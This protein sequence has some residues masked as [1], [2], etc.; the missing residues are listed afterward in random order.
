MDDDIVEFKEVEDMTEINGKQ[1]SVKVLS[2]CRFE[3][4]D[5]RGFSSFYNKGIA[6]KVKIPIKL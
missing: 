1:F 5:T 2:E 3:I 6:R 4:G